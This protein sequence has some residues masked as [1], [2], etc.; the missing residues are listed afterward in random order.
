MNAPV[1]ALAGQIPSF[2][3]DRGPRPPARN[4]RPARPAAPHHQACRTHQ[5]AARSAAHGG[6]G[7]AHRDHRPPGPVALECAIDTWGQRPKSHR[8]AI[9]RPLAPAR[10]SGSSRR[11]RPT[12]PE[13]GA[14][15]ADRG[16][17]RRARRRRRG[18]GDRRS[19]QA[20]VS[21]F[22]RGRGVIPT[23]IRSRCRSPKAT[24]CGRTPTRCWRSARGSTGSRATG[25]S[26]TICRSCAWTSTPRRSTASAVPPVPWWA[27]RRDP[28]RALLAELP[29]HNHPE[30]P[31][32]GTRRRSPGIQ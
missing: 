2:A 15:A 26:M 3:I 21:S 29:A 10:R 28:V 20:P 8:P 23:T 22:R 19:L 6:R 14:A 17:R 25:A 7:A 30:P 1:I 16:G 27:T 11:A 9:A 18:A 31:R 4:P 5:R 12:A 13:P 24:H 32:R